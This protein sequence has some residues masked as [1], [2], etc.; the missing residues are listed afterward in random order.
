MKPRKVEYWISK[1]VWYGINDKE[2][3]LLNRAVNKVITS[4]VKREKSR[5]KLSMTLNGIQGE[6]G[7]MVALETMSMKKHPKLWVKKTRY[8]WDDLDESK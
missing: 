1:R 3:E 7:L 8:V 4:V 6:V 2:R 5:H